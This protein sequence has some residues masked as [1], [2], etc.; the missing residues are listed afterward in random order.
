MR[1]I[2]NTLLYVLICLLAFAS[3]RVVAAPTLSDAG[4]APVLDGGF[5]Q[6]GPDTLER[7]SDDDL[8]A[9]VRRMHDLGM[10]VLII[11]ST[12]TDTHDANGDR[13]FG[14]I[15]NTVY[16]VHPAYEGRNP[17][18]AIFA[19]CD[20][21]NMRVY[22]GGLPFGRPEESTYADMIEQWSSDQALRYREQVIK[23]Y[24]GYTSF[25][26]FYI[27]I[28]PNP[29]QLVS[30]RCD[31]ALLLDAVDKV[32][33][34][35]KSTKTDLHV[36]MPIGMYLRPIG[37]GKYLRSKRQEL[38]HFWRPWVE[39]LE[40]VDTWMIIDGLGDKSSDLD[41][42]A[43][44]Q[45]WAR[46]LAHTYNKTCWTAVQTTNQSIMGKRNNDGQP[47]AFTDLARSLAVASRFADQILAM[48]YLDSLSPV[49]DR[50]EAAQRHGAYTRYLQA[51]NQEQG[52]PV[53]TVSA[54]T[55]SPGPIRSRP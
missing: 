28:R 20:Q 35:V 34:A 16:P 14:M 27:P 55:T 43:M 1:A 2:R 39:R 15:W 50:S 25:E 26:G 30:N 29:Y 11:Q 32:T 53:K 49:A 5:W 42:T 37:D 17:L 31:P 54:S 22:L 6:F 36:L 47:L 21:M 4:H 52:A 10:R 23:R 41:H 51:F 7:Y 33:Q 8:V 40:Q 46:D 18:R 3:P 12:V 13:R 48:D 45:R 38:N 9:E 24:A 44:A 19:A